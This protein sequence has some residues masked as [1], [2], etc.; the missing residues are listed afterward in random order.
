M[1]RPEQR[2]LTGRA[3]TLRRAAS[4]RL[5]S[6]PNP[7]GDSAPDQTAPRTAG[8]PLS[9]TPAARAGR[10]RINPENETAHV[11]AGRRLRPL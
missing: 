8:A 6:G 3:S 1:T 9:A 11:V 2:R 5:N 7:A 4:C 10:I